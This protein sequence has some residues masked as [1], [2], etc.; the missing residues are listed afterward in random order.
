MQKN[1][2][3]LSLPG[4]FSEKVADKL[5]SMEALT[6]TAYNFASYTGFL[7]KD[8]TAYYYAGSTDEIK[9]I[10]YHT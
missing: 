1:T 8:S 3:V 6:P 10:F 7:K 5:M 9:N 2:W 4:L